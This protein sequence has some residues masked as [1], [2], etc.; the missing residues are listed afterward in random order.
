M[1][2]G[3]DW[4]LFNILEDFREGNDKLSYFHFGKF[5]NKL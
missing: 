4:K 3:K 5:L 2:F 1:F